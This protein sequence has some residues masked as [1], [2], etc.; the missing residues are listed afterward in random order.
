MAFNYSPKPVI[1]S[2]LVLYLDAANPRSYVSGSSVWGD[3]SRGGN[4]G[5]LVGGVTYNSSNN[6][7]LVFNGSTGYVDG[8]NLLYG[9]SKAT[10]HAWVKK[11]NVS[12]Q[13][14]FGI[15]DSLS[16]NRIE[17]VWYTNGYLYGECG[18]NENVWVNSL[19][20]IID[21]NW[22][23]IS[24]VYD[25]TKSTNY[26]K[27]T[28]YFDGVLLTPTAQ[29]GTIASTITTTGRMIIGNRSKGYSNGRISNLQIYKRALSSTEVRQNYNA[30]K[31][32]YG[33]R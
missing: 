14:S 30:L 10:L 17:I 15:M 20:P 5:T 28:I 2:S 23:F 7:S 1:D 32:R 13:I 21:T 12:N 16:G 29:L 3:V 22:H 19:P 26:E 25:G 27:I 31:G 24:I 18:P 9:E 4:N 33:L 8:P 6:G 11:T